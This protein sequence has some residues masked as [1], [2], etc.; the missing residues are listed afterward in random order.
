M[1]TLS[2]NAGYIATCLVTTTAFVVGMTTTFINGQQEMRLNL[3]SISV[4]PPTTGKLHAKECA[5]SPL[6]A[7]RRESDSA[8]CVINKCTSSGLVKMIAQN[9]KAYLMSTEIYDDF[10]KLLKLT[11]AHDLTDRTLFIPLYL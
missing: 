3:Y 5:S 7:V 9:G 1:C 10:F 2:T 11:I 8:T 6:S 4:G